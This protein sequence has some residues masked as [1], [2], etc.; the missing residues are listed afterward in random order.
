[1]LR[2]GVPVRQGGWGLVALGIRSTAAARILEVQRVRRLLVLRLCATHGQTPPYFSPDE[3]YEHGAPGGF[4]VRSVVGG[5]IVDGCARAL[6]R[7]RARATRRWIHRTVAASGAT[8]PSA[9]MAAISSSSFSHDPAGN[10]TG[11]AAA[12]TPNGT[13]PSGPESNE[14]TSLVEQAQV[15]FQWLVHQMIR[16][17]VHDDRLHQTFDAGKQFRIFRARPAA[18]GH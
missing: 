2:F 8:A 6:R 17:I 4:A 1:M 11:A 18:S 9:S 16:W 13:K 12:A 15:I 5:A 10:L 7:K 3:A 14:D